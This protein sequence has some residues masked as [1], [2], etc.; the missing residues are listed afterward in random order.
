MQHAPAIIELRLNR[1]A[2]LFHTLDPSPFR[3][4]D[5]DAVAEDYILGQAQALPGPAPLAIRISLPEAELASPAAAQIPD[6][7]Q[8][9][10]ARRVEA[11]RRGLAELFREGRIA[12]VIGV[13]FLGLALLA[14]V[15]A[16]LLL[17]EGRVA[18]L[19]GES[20]III[21]WVA[22]W[23]PAQI[24]LYG[25]LPGR[26]SLLIFRRLSRAEVTLIPTG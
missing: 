23:H 9:H 4:G 1:A 11:E 19:L 18:T 15:Q 2:Q 16:P 14:A 21:G 6:A 10:F 13:V 17:G 20:L 7:V 8:R 5:L 25:W 26:R 12:L 24:F 3:E 22:L